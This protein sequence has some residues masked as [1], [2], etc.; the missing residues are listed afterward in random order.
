MFANETRVAY[1]KIDIWSDDLLLSAPASSFSR[2]VINKNEQIMKKFVNDWARF[3][4]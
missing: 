1:P 2:F 4:E 3:Q